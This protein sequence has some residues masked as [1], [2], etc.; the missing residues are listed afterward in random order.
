MSTIPGRTLEAYVMW[1]HDFIVDGDNSANESLRIAE[2]L[3]RPTGRVCI[4]GAE[5]VRVLECYGPWRS[6]IEY[7]LNTFSE[8]VQSWRDYAGYAFDFLP[9]S[10]LNEA[11][12]R[13]KELREKGAEGR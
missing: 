10:T 7:A 6:Q 1:E 9:T 2:S 13:A 5:F 3:G 12:R 8:D 4:T 11:D